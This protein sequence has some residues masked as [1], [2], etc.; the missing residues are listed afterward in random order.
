[1]S[2]EVKLKITEG[3]V[4]GEEFVFEEHDTFIFGRMKD[5]HMCL[6]DDPCVSRHHFIME[7]NPP[8]VRLRDLG[9]LNGTYVNDKKYGGRE[10][11]ETPEEGTRRQYPQVDLRDGDQIRVGGTVFRVS[12]ELPA[13]CV[14]CGVEI[15]DDAREQC[16]WVGGTY[17]CAECR[18]K[19]EAAEKPK[20]P[21]KRPEPVRCKICGKDVSGEIGSARRGDYVCAACR[22]KVLADPSALLMALL[23]QAL[24]ARAAAEFE[25]PDYEIVSKLGEGGMGAVY[26]VRHKRTGERAALKVMLSKVAVDERMRKRFMREIESMRVLRHKHIVQLYDQGSAG[27]VFY[28]LMEFCEGGS[29]DKLMEPQGGR[30]SLDEAGLIMLQALEGL[31]FAH[32]RDFV[33]RDLKPQ[34]ILLTGRE[35]DWT[36]KIADLGFAKNFD[37]AGLSGPTITGEYA[38]TRPFMPREQVTNFKRVKPVTD[39]WAM[40]ATL[41]NMLTGRY[42]YDFRRGQDPVAVILHGRIV[43]IRERNPR[44]PRR[45][46]KVIDRS[47]AIKTKDRYQDAG[48]MRKALE[49]V[50]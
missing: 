30:L 40:G 5:C 32:Q 19:I 36:A 31:A 37:E 7:V 3:V 9:S 15:P 42:P 33:H 21:P 46:A 16:A 12:V 23:G 20:K 29:V 45:V 14:E 28:F 24:G 38:G 1:M 8:D 4:R 34:N 2:G 49:R 11:H 10:K 43:P 41:Y 26:L 44:I 17:I 18:R 25:I 50:L 35:G 6:P 13:E 27:S 39:V 22:R 48:E 47:L